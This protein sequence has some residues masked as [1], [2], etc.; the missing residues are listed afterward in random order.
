MREL[1]KDIEVRKGAV[2]V[3][4]GG[5]G[6]R[7]G[8]DGQGWKSDTRRLE[9]LRDR[10]HEVGGRTRGFRANDVTRLTAHYA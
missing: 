1:E 6:T 10:Q 8:A 5:V 4:D 2:M 7:G 9:A 3:I